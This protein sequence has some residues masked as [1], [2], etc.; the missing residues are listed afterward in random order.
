MSTNPYLFKK[1]DDGSKDTAEIDKLVELARKAQADF[2]K[3][4]D[5]FVA[6]MSSDEH[7]ELRKAYAPQTIDV[8]SPDGRKL[9]KA[10]TKHAYFC[11]ADKLAIFAQR[12][13]EPV[14]NE[15]GEF[16]IN[17]GGD[18]LTV[19]PVTMRDARESA[20][21]KES[22]ARLKHYKAKPKRSTIGED[23]SDVEFDGEQ[24]EIKKSKM[25]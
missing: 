24:V 4:P 21:W 1:K 3:A 11:E 15:H 16:V 13:Y 2:T 20:N 19:C 17:H 5:V 25:E 8:Y 22:E 7:M 9:I 10:A 18:V 23:V 12:G 14:R 6:D